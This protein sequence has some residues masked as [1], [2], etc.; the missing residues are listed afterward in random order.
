MDIQAKI[1]DGQV[2]VK[3]TD[4]ERVWPGQQQEKRWSAPA[5][6]QPSAPIIKRDLYERKYNPNIV[7]IHRPGAYCTTEVA[8]SLGISVYALNKFLA[9]RGW[10]YK[11]DKAYVARMSLDPSYHRSSTIRFRWGSEKHD[12]RWTKAGADAVRAL[13]YGEHQGG[14]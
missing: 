10:I 2:W 3:A 4:A 5:P 1:I 9:D 14:V 8:Q 6:V 7:S 13:W 12:L 11:C